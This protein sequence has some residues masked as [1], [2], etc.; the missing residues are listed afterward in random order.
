MKIIAFSIV[1]SL[2]WW[3]KKPAYPTLL[4]LLITLC[5][6]NVFAESPTTPPP[7]EPT[8]YNASQD[9]TKDSLQAKIDALTARKGLD[10]ALKSRIIAAYQSA[11]DELNNIKAFNE[12][13]I[14]LK[15]LFNKPL[16]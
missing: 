12:R 11:Q 14:A 9:I 7:P 1:P 6:G 2:F 15:R 10:E 5:S 16:T 3:A 13:E 8:N 4:L